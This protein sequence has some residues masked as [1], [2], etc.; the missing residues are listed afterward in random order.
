[1]SSISAAI[2]KVSQKEDLSQEEAHSAM[3]AIMSGEAT[4]AQIGGYLM[5]LRLKGES[6]AE[7]TGSVQ[8]MRD[9]VNRVDTPRRTSAIDTCGTGG[10]GADTFNISTTV[11][12]VA[13]AAGIPVAKHG[14]R[15]VSSKSGSADV[16]MALGVE[17]KL[18]PEQVAQCIDAVGIGFMFAPGFH[19]AMKHAIGPRR[20]LGVRT[21]FNI[22]GPL[23]NPAGVNRQ[24]LGVF[25]PALTETLATVLHKLG[26]ER[27]FVVHGAGGLDEFSTLGNNQ[28]SALR[29][30]TL[31]SFTL[32]PS[33]HNLKKVSLKDIQGGDAEHNA[34]ITRAVLSGGG[35][36]AQREIVMLNA[37]AAL[38]VGGVVED[39]DSGLEKA[40]QIL[41]SGAGTEKLEALAAYTQKLA[42]KA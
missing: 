12:F 28:V 23:T 33:D 25:D 7:I 22:L 10:D 16:L 30:G 27:V 35:S 8:A 6:P 26:S 15:A 3:Q 24:V 42:A 39:F 29:D 5:A 4:P 36:T 37:A 31:Q 11:A 38:I 9:V 41:D 2:R 32:D 18:L 40:A 20:E 13:A 14:N 19:P 1:M 17:V 34:A 21:I